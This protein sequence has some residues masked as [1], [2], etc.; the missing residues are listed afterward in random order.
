VLSVR[1]HPSQLVPNLHRPAVRAKD[2]YTN[3]DVGH[4]VFDLRSVSS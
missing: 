2:V 1:L 3:G 4:V